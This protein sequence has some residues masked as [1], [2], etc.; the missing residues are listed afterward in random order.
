M[1]SNTVSHFSNYFQRY[2]LYFK[3]TNL[4]MM[5]TINALIDQLVN[6]FLGSLIIVLVINQPN[7]Y[8]LKTFLF[9]YKWKWNKLMFIFIDAFYT[10]VLILTQ[11]LTLQQLYGSKLHRLLDSNKIVQTNIYFQYWIYMTRWLRPGNWQKSTK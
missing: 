9:K 4:Y 1:H 11:S 8:L 2:V 3:H 6:V 5:N 10:S 7:L